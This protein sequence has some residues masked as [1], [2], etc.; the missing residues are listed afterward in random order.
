MSVRRSLVGG[1]WKCNNTMQ[2]TQNLIS[3]VVN[4]LV[5]DTSRVEVVVAPVNLHLPYALENVQSD[6]NVSA[7]NVSLTGMGAYTGETSVEH[8]QDMGCNWTITGHSERRA[9]FG[10]SDQ[11]VADK[12]KR[13]VD[14]GMNVIACCGETQGER[15]SGN[16]M[17]VVSR[18]VTALTETL[19]ES[20]W[21]QVT[22]AYE[23][24]WAIGTGL[25]ATPDQAQEVH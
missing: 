25:V 24:V 1:N 2:F 18:L 23:P 14:M 7:Q 11:D 22:I 8:L 10:E 3:N 20:D 4:K 15:E 12:T 13:A 17:N 21:S 19:D 6:V 5:F 16:T 9:L